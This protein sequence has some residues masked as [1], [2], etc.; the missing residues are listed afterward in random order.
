MNLSKV[1]LRFYCIFFFSLFLPEPGGGLA[2]L[3]DE[4]G[5]HAGISQKVIELGHEIGRLLY[6]LTFVFNENNAFTKKTIKLK[7]SLL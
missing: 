7:N 5:G 6:F 2:Q 4:Q 3:Q 1:F